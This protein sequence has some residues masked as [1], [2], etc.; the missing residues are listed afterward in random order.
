MPASVEPATV[1][2]TPLGPSRLWWTKSEATSCNRS[3]QRDALNPSRIDCFI[4][5]YIR[6][7]SVSRLFWL[8]WFRG[9]RKT[10]LLSHRDLPLTF[11]VSRCNDLVSP[12][13]IVDGARF[14]VALGQS[15][16]AVIE[17]L[18]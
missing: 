16:A 7:A 18:Q 5:V 17:L 1:I 13:Q 3:R 6:T 8:A 10:W 9:A 12:H 11:G 15:A 4:T 14:R 2:Q